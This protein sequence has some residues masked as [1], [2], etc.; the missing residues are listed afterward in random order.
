MGVTKT[1]VFSEQDVMLAN[2]AKALAHPARIAIL[3]VLMRRQA[4][5]CGDI[6]DEIPLAQST[7]S[8]HLKALKEAELIQ[9]DVEGTS[10]CYCLNPKTWKKL[11]V[12]L[13]GFIEAISQSK[14]CC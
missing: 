5:V 9:G 8:Q 13:L 14:S 3:N 2:F 10:V 1:E 4:C 11:G 7:I 12:D 6:V